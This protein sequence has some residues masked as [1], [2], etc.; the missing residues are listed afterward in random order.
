MKDELIELL[1]SKEHQRWAKWQKYLHSCCTKNEDG[2]LTIPKDKVERW[3]RQMKTD[4][5]NL[6]EKEKISD[7]RQVIETLNTI[8]NYHKN[9]NPKGIVVAGFGAIGKTWLGEH[10][11]NIIDMESGYYKHNNEG[12]EN[13]DVEK[14]KGTT[15]RPANPYW[16][17]NYYEAILNAR[18]HYDIILTSMHWD[19]LKFYQDNNIPYYLAFPNQGL[20]E[21]YA[22][23][24]YNRGNNEIFTKKMIENI[25]IWYKK[26]KDYKPV[27]ILYLKSGEFLEDVL[28]K[29]NLI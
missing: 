26:L 6:T 10:Y 13:I 2:S 14:R 19:L 18:K 16:P 25:E 4:Y 12:F 22:K 9:K 7:R 28:L 29:E 23:R 21:E 3:N 24:C 1:S 15:I 8:K 5:E 27:K 20:E 11:S 17:K